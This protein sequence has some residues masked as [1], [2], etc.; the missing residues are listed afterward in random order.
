MVKKYLSTT[1][2][3]TALDQNMR[4]LTRFLP[5]DRSIL[6]GLRRSPLINPYS[7]KR[8]MGKL[9][10]D[11]SNGKPPIRHSTTGSQ[12]SMM[13][14]EAEFGAAAR[15]LQALGHPLSL[16]ILILLASGEASATELQIHLRRPLPTISVHLHRLVDRG[17]LRCRSVGPRLCYKLRDAQV[18]ALVASINLKYLN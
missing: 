4:S 8:K 2:A 10:S 18:A 13:N 12:R 16:G 5:P 1:K 7:K 14:A 9:N 3:G 11:I 15:C 6:P 17:L